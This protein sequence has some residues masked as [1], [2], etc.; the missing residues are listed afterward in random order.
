MGGF[1]GVVSKTDCVNDLFY[2]TDYHSHLGTRRGGLAV[3]NSDGF[4]R[5]IHD[6]TNSQFRS[7]FENDIGKMK[8]NLG[9]GVISDNED[10]PLIIASHLGDYAIA[11]VGVI[12]NLNA[13]KKEA[14]RNR[15]THFSEMSNGEINP[16]ELIATLINQEATFEDGIRRAQETIAESRDRYADLYDLAPVGY[17]TLDPQGCIVDLNLT[18]ARLLGA[19]RNLLLQQ[20]FIL[21]VA[22]ECRQT[23]YD[24]LRQLSAGAALQSCEL[25]LNPQQG[26]AGA[27]SLES[28]AMVE[29]GGQS[30]PVSHGHHRHH[31]APQRRG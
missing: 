14:F 28:L 19:P 18:G 31:P 1:F 20:P 26:P 8:G 7:K 9:I 5:F 11:T 16:T 2:G 23:F 22:P 4:T 21:F 3:R 12:T 17:V 25:E 29:A 10:Q 15:T 30:H 24:Y 6:I 27:V 13:I